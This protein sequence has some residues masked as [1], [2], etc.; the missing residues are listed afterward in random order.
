MRLLTF[1]MLYGHSRISCLLHKFRH[2]FVLACV[3]GVHGSVVGA[4]DLRDIKLQGLRFNSCH[5]ALWLAFTSGYGIA[6]LECL[7]SS[8]CHMLNLRGS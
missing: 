4:L 5:L 2:Y 8:L 1:W 3:M 7:G 6:S